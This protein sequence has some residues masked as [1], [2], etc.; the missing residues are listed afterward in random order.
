[1]KGLPRVWPR[2]RAPLVTSVAVAA[3]AGILVHN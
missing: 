3:L 2:C 1:M